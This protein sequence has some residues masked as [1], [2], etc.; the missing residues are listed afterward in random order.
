MPSEDSRSPRRAE[1]GQLALLTPEEIR[2]IA[3]F[4]VAEYVEQSTPAANAPSLLDRA[5]L[6]KAL[7]ASKS[8][9]DRYRRAGMPCIMLGDSPRFDVAEVIGWLR[10]QPER[11]RG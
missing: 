9:I 8:K 6:G 4:A 5:A 3:K 1:L 10:A 11:R 2:A 7:D